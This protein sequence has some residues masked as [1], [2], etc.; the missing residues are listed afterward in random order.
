MMHSEAWHIE[1]I[2]AV[3]EVLLRVLRLAQDAEVEFDALAAL[4]EQEPALTARVLRL[5]TSACFRPWSAVT[6]LRRLLVVLGQE[7]IRQ[8]AVTSAVQQ[9]FSQIPPEHEALTD[10][11]WFRSL[12][13]AQLSRQLAQLTAYP[14]PEE[15][16][17]AG[18]LHA[19][20]QLVLLQSFPQRCPLLAADAA[21]LTQL[22]DIARDC[23]G[24]PAAEVAARLLVRWGLSP[25]LADAVR[26]QNQPAQELREAAP[27]VQLV[28]LALRLVDAAQ[29]AQAVDD[30][31]LG[32]NAGLLQELIQQASADVAALA[33]DLGLSPAVAIERPARQALAD[34]VR[35]LAL[36]AG[37]R[38][39]ADSGADQTALLER[40][41]QDLAL[42][43]NLDAP[44]FLLCRDGGQ[45]VGQSSPLRP[46]WNEIVL[47]WPDSASRVAEALRSGQVQLTDEHDAL[48]PLPDR[49]MAG[50]L[51]QEG[52]LVLPLV[53]GGMPLAAVVAGVGAAQG[54][55]LAAQM[56][57]LQLF[58]DQLAL[59][60]A[61]QR[62]W[63]QETAERLQGERDHYQL[64]VRKLLHEV[65]NPLTVI[66]NYL[67]V[68]QQKLDDPARTEELV[69]LQDELVRVGDLLARLRQ[70]LE[71][72][73]ATGEPARLGLN[74]LL[75]DL[76]RLFTVS[77]LA[78]RGLHLE[79]DLDEGIP[80]LALSGAALRQLVLNL[81]RNAAEALPAGGQ[82]RLV[83]RDRVY[84]NGTQLVE[85]RI[86]DDGP[87]LPEA[88]LQRLFQPVTS[89][90]AGHAGLGLVIVRNLVEQLGGEISCT[91]RAAA[92][93]SFQILLPRRLLAQE[94]ADAG[95]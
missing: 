75:R 48:M 87:G 47:H 33:Q 69:L 8:L 49:Q 76:G 93:T 38:T 62:Q 86:E 92:G 27:L 51:G 15:A 81:V 58:A 57:L 6:Q 46:R 71:P 26:Y 50:L 41:R 70:P 18:L 65:N 13:C 79:L 63:R 4:I 21:A 7:R 56:S 11:L 66:G 28:N 10:R 5:A 61:R 20:G 19:L 25:L 90:K 80:P 72:L 29:T 32:L 53:T 23:F 3:P 43:F 17:L 67:H 89:S 77:L 73:E 85:L 24:C 39:A 34:Q 40:M 52:L 88:V 83:T 35:G 9:V 37:C 59:V 95:A 82:L 14:H 74:A 55:R 1:Q 45:L 94:S 44:E 22:Q 2:A 78:G 84:K 36:L 12:L 64:Q 68:L 30:P 60:L 91:S 54:R 31:L 42:V 16:Y